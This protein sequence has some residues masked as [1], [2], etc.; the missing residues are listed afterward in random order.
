[1]IHPTDEQTAK[2]A[3]LDQNEPV[4][5]IN[6]HKYSANARYPDGYDSAQ[7]PPAVTG[8]GA[9]QRFLWHVEEALMPLVGGRM[10]VAGPVAAV[11][12]GDADWDD[13][14]IGE[15]PSIADALRL[16]KLP[17]YETAAIHRKA[18]LERVQTIILIQDDMQRMAIQ[19]A[20]ITRV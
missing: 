10:L 16:F 19:G 18:G 14:I 4:I 12:I 1:M 15:F 6:L 3:A 9:Y 2:L 8:R 7:F 11:L 17:G 5:F 13:A 20:W